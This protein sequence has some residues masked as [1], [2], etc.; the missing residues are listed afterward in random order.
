VWRGGKDSIKKADLGKEWI[1]LL[2][3]KKEM[4]RS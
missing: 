1:D 4:I 2:A 3:L